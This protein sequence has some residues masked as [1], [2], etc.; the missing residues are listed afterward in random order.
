[1]FKRGIESCINVILKMIII[2]IIKIIL[3]NRRKATRKPA[4]NKENN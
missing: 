3:G 2:L 1:M 4:I